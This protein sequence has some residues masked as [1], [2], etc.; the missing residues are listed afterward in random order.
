MNEESKRRLAN[1]LGECWHERLEPF[2]ASTYCK[3]CNQYFYDWDYVLNRTFTT[4]DDYFAVFDRL[5]ELGEWEEFYMFATSAY[6]NSFALLW[7]DVSEWAVSRDSTG[8]DQ[9]K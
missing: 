1:F 8:G 3:K 9:L 2:H 7:R 4:P 5:V 6:K